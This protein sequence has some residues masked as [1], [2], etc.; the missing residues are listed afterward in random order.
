MNKIKLF[1]AGLFL[2]L[3]ITATGFS[4]TATY[5]VTK[6]TDPDPF[7]HPYN[8]VD[9][10]CDTAMYGTLAWSIN[11]SNDDG[12][13]SN[14][15]FAI[16]GT[17]IH[18]I[19]LN[20]SLPTI[21]GDITIDGTT[22]NGYSFPDPSI[23]IDGQNN[24]VTGLSLLKIQNSIINGI[25]I[26]N[27]LT[28]GIAVSHSNNVTISNCIINDINNG[29]SNNEAAIAIL[30]V[31]SPNCNIQGSY[32]GTNPSSDSLNIEDYGIML[33]LNSNNNLVG[34]SGLN[35]G[36][37]IAY[38]W[39]GIFVN[40]SINDKISRN[41]IYNNLQA[42]FLGPGANNN[43]AAPDSL[44]YNDST[45]VLSG[46]AEPFDSIEVFGSTGPENANTYL[47]TTQA[48]ANGSW[49]IQVQTADS[50]LVATATNSANNTSA[51][52]NISNVAITS[53]ELNFYQI[54]TQYTEM[55]DFFTDSAEGSEFTSIKRI[56][57]NLGPRL[58]PHGDMKI[59]T[60]AIYDYLEKFKNNQ[61]RSTTVNANWHCLGPN[62]NPLDYNG[63]IDTHYHFVGQIHRITFDPRYDGI[64][65]GV[66]QK[67]LYAASTFG[68][69]WKSENKGDLWTLMGTDQLP[70]TSVSD[71]VVSYQN[72]DNNF[73]I[74]TGDA[75]GVNFE[76]QTYT[77]GWEYSN[78]IYTTGVYRTIDGGSSWESINTGLINFLINIGSNAYGNGA[79]CR[80]M[81]VDP[82]DENILYVGT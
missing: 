76:D 31:V 30:V 13:P 77:S 2:L 26:R 65:T 59:T 39:R 47:G 52:S 10:L 45:Q 71:I 25:Y 44:Q 29:T 61:F 34:G 75:D 22:Q 16:P 82:N 56:Y 3:G 5:T 38:C 63:I 57:R 64:N 41:I 11:K 49:S 62:K 23:I 55:P 32:I 54:M 6:V 18:I 46:I 53:H 12:V 74:C 21:S 9:S 78:P 27:F 36:N 19:L 37:T 50:F 70:I 79:V 73:F 7:V 35:Q 68:G 67:T 43:K 58:F 20:Y 8:Y 1:F 80:R 15:V 48:D 42:I 72:P 81:I 28:H 51:L 69:L 17:D 66:G 4:Q 40:G 24:I 60:A 14:I 33:W